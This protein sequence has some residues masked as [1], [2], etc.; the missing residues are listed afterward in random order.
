M[1]QCCMDCGVISPDQTSIA[2]DFV[3]SGSTATQSGWLIESRP[4]LGGGV[5]EIVLCFPCRNLVPR[6]RLLALNTPN[7]PNCR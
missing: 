6:H 1:I 3:V 4:T 7:A 5:I 2:P